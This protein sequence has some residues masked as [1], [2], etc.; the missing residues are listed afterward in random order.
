MGGR[1]VGLVGGAG[2]LNVKRE[3]SEDGFSGEN[4]STADDL[5]LIARYA[6]QKPLIRET[7]SKVTLR[8]TFYLADGVT[9]QDI[10][11]DRNTNLM[12]DSGSE[13]Y[14]PGANGLKTGS[15]DSAGFCLIVTAKRDGR[16]LM[17][18]VLGAPRNQD[19]W[20]DAA[21][22]LDAGFAS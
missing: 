1:H 11:W 12:I 2:G 8:D 16:E 10:T 20:A 9:K 14:Y 17:A 5:L 7:A 15:S 13:A 3:I 18:I 6:M 19:R 21:A 4:L 22:L